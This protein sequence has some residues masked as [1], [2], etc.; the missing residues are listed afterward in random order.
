[1]RTTLIR[2][3]VMG[4]FTLSCVG[5]WA[6]NQP[7]CQPPM[8]TNQPAGQT[9]Y[10]FQNVTF[11]VTVDPASTTPLSYQWRTNGVNLLASDRMP[12]VTAPTLTIFELSTNDAALYSVVVSNSCV[13][14][15]TNSSDALL[16]VT[17][18]NPTA[19]SDG[20]GVNNLTELLQGRNHLTAYGTTP[21]SGNRI[22]LQVFTPLQ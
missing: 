2:C 21:D 9:R 3:A 14:G 6:Q 8:I 7:V 5:L 18:V 13:N 22:N 16:T 19:D 20:D 10:Q 11:S 4:A 17:A 1:M 15:I 12:S